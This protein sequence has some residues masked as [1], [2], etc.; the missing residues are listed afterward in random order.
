M[1]EGENL[2]LRGGAR[3]ITGRYWVARRANQMGRGPIGT[4][5]VAAL[6]LAGCTG[7]PWR[8]DC[9]A[10]LCGECASAWREIRKSE[11]VRTTNEESWT[12]ACIMAKAMRP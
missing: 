5:L 3:G 8:Q 6:L 1:Q 10:R 2:T 4:V 7:A 9:G 12:L 11:L